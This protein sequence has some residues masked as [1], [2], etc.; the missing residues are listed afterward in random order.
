MIGPFS[1]RSIAARMC[2][3]RGSELGWERSEHCGRRRGR[4]VVEKQLTSVPHHYVV[5]MI[6]ILSTFAI[7]YMEGAT[8]AGEARRIP[9]LDRKQRNGS[10]GHQAKERCEWT[11]GTGLSLKGKEGGRMG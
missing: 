11:W 1:Q 10:A 3:H 7:D 8:N 2:L 9:T 5:E 6:L 4:L